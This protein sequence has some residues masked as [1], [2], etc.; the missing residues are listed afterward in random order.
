LITRAKHVRGHILTEDTE[1]QTKALDAGVGIIAIQ[2]LH[3]LLEGVSEELAEV[4]PPKRALAPG[5]IL[6]VRMDRRGR[7]DGQGIGFLDDGRKVVV[8]NGASKLGAEVDVMVDHVSIDPSGKQTVFA[9][10]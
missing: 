5:E 7:D 4:C 10:L 6:M 1:L 8:S 2:E 3:R 9:S